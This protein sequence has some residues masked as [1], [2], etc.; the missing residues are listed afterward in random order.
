MKRFN[1]LKISVLAVFI[2]FLVA[3]CVGQRKYEDTL[4][5][6]TSAEQKAKECENQ[7]KILND[8]LIVLSDAYKQQYKIIANLSS[9]TS[10]LGSSNR[11][12]N[13][14]Y[15]RINNQYELLLNKLKEETTSS[16]FKMRELAEQ[17]KDAERKVKEREEALKL[18]ETQIAKREQELQE[19]QAITNQLK[20]NLNEKDAKLGELQRLLSEKDSATKALKEVM[21]NALVGFAGKGLS[22]EQKN[23]KVYLS[24]EEKLLFQ[25]GKFVV[26]KEGKVALLE[27]SKALSNLEDIDILVEGHTDNVPLKGSG[28]LSD[29]WD[30]SVRRA[31]EVVKILTIEGKLSEKKIVASGRGET[32]PIADNSTKEGR[33]KNRRTEIILTPKLAELYELIDGK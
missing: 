5:K 14:M 6:A 26:N 12:I 18:K 19:K 30:L 16:T 10:L 22:V 28:A 17:L 8:S 13:E 4:S 3:S 27:I 7:N 1:S 9:D 11:K 29:N 33:A 23:G 15:T 31:T 20:E 21:T 25:S 24:V 2:Y 32:Q